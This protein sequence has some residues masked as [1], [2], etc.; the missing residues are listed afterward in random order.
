M[1][2]K[3]K[4]DI[5]T[6]ISLTV[7]QCCTKDLSSISVNTVGLPTLQLCLFFNLF[8]MVCLGMLYFLAAS[9]WPILPVRKQKWTD[10]IYNAP[11]GTRMNS[12]DS[13][14]MEQGVFDDWFE[15]HFLPFALKKEGRRVIIGDNL[16]SHIS[17]RTLELCEQNNIKFICLPPN[18]THLLQPLDVAYF[19]SL[20]KN[21]RDVL[22]QWRKTPEGKKKQ[23]LPK[24]TFSGLLAKTLQLGEQTASSNLVKGFEKCGLCPVNCDRVLQCLPDYARN[25]SSV[26]GSVGAEFKKYLETIR[27][28]DLNVKCVKKYKLPIEPGKSVST[29]DV[30]AFYENRELTRN[31]GRRRQSQ[32]EGG[33]NELRGELEFQQC[34]TSRPRSG[35]KTRGGVRARAATLR[36]LNRSNLPTDASE[37]CILAELDVTRSMTDRMELVNSPIV[38]AE[39]NMVVEEELLTD[40]VNQPSTSEGDFHVNDYVIAVYEGKCYPGKVTAVEVRGNCVTFR[41]SCMVKKGKYWVWPERE[42]SIW[43]RKDCILKKIDES[44]MKHINKRGMVHISDDLLCSSDEDI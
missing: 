28:S 27:Q 24:G 7:I 35:P 19:S 15:T 39:G 38:I 32:I 5:G 23:C 26:M 22:S 30:R 1:H 14:W 11:P 13:G 9:L 10:W 17:I 3:S 31:N 43:Y 41:I 6:P 40:M 20:K 34:G 8:T 42:D 29:E 4:I 37:S 44:C 25:E 12:S 21:W 33:E 16:S 36:T 2:L 18:A